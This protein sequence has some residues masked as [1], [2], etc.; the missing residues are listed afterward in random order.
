M[1][2]G[3]VVGWNRCWRRRQGGDRIV[4]DAIF[5]SWGAGRGRRRRRG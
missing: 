5:K 3:Q 4:W 2:V 1:V